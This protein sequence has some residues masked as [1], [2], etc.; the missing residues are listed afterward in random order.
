MIIRVAGFSTPLSILLSA[1]K[2]PEFI[3]DSKSKRKAPIV[4][5][6]GVRGCNG[7]RIIPV[8][9]S[10]WNHNITVYKKDPVS[11]PP[12]ANLNTAAYLRQFEYLRLPQKEGLHKIREKQLRA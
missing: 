9:I 3:P 12:Y 7:I 4:N 8:N 10:K 11:A 1:A 2:R 5:S 6:T